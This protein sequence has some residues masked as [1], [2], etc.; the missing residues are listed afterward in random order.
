MLQETG[1]PKTAKVKTDSGACIGMVHR[2][3]VG[4]MKHLE[5]RQ[6]WVQDK[7]AEGRL[8]VQKVPR[9]ANPRDLL[10]HHWTRSDG[11]AH[12]KNMGCSVRSYDGDV[13]VN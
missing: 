8:V 1:D 4:R 5:V 13:N 6:L 9:A 7:V 12:L 3:G 11:E 10:A 2:R